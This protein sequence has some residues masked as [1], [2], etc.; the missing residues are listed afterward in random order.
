MVQIVE[1]GE[2][3]LDMVLNVQP[4]QRVERHRQR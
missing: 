4:T 1:K 3:V 2:T